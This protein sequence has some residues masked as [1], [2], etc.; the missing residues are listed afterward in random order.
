MSEQDKR[1]ANLEL[2]IWPWQHAYAA[3]VTLPS[4]LALKKKTSQCS[5]LGGWNHSIHEKLFPDDVPT[6]PSDR[7]VR[8]AGQFWESVSATASGLLLANVRGKKID[9]TKVR[10]CCVHVFMEA[11]L[12]APRQA[13]VFERARHGEGY[14][15]FLSMLRDQGRHT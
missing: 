6:A 13:V 14:C 2:Q 8:A 9:W 11:S 4:F 7:S 3:V 5:W 15:L 12:Q 1:K 10:N